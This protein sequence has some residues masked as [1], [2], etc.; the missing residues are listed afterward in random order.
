MVNMLG[1]PLDAVGRLELAREDCGSMPNAAAA[2]ARRP[3][4]PCTTM[5]ISQSPSLMAAAAWRTCSMNEQPPTEVAS[6]QVGVM[7]RYQRKFGDATRGGDA[8]D[9]GRLESGVSEG[10]EGCIGVDAE[11][12]EVGMIPSSVDSAAPTTATDFCFT[13]ITL[14]PDGRSAG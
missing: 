14:P 1:G 6:T 10:V 5:A 8:V 9:I 3:L 4:S 12:R 7:P 11:L 2:D 13:V